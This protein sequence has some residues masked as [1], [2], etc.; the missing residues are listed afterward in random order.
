MF[1]LKKWDV[2]SKEEYLR[3]VYRLNVLILNIIANEQYNKCG[4]M[5][6]ERSN[7]TVV[8]LG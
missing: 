5:F 2:L 4:Q 3:L 7:L 6:A 1:S 8:N